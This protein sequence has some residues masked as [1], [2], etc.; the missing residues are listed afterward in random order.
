MKIVQGQPAEILAEEIPDSVLA[1]VNNWRG[2]GILYDA[3]MDRASY[4]I[5]FAAIGDGRQYRTA[6]GGVIRTSADQN[7]MM[8]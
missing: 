8:N 4:D 3:L 1:F 7:L 6:K 2:E 5:F